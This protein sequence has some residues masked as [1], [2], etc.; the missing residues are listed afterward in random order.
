MAAPGPSK[1]RILAALDLTEEASPSPPSL[2]LHLLS[3]QAGGK[4][5]RVAEYAVAPLN[6]RQVSGTSRAAVNTLPT[7]LLASTQSP[8]AYPIFFSFFLSYVMLMLTW[9]RWCPLLD[10]VVTDATL[11]PEELSVRATQS[12][13]SASFRQSSSLDDPLGSEFRVS[14]DAE[15]PL[16][17]LDVGGDDQEQ[18]H[19]HI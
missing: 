13:I 10:A 8:G 16:T 17:R 9:D 1:S 14:Y 11:T 18:R 15:S 6:K 3:R 4:R 7:G 12:F 2:P 19:V 5:K